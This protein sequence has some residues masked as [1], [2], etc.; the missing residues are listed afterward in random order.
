[1]FNSKYYVRDQSRNKYIVEVSTAT[2]I[3]FLQ[4]LTNATASTVI[5]HI[6]ERMVEDRDVTL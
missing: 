5:T 6:V 4:F 2:P 1:M 3:I